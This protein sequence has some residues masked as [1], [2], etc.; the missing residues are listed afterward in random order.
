MKSGYMAQCTHT[1][2]TLI[3]KP[4]DRL[5]CRYCHLTLKAE[6][7]E[8][9]YCPECL[10]VSG[11]KRADFEKIEP[12]KETVQYRCEECGAMLVGGGN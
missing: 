4:A 11:H 10:A 2:I 3:P 5:R 9:G 6:E 8:N 1:N 12:E 7:L